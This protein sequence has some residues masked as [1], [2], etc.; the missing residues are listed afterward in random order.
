MTYTIDT[1][2]FLRAVL[3]KKAVKYVNEIISNTAPRGIF[4]QPIGVEAKHKLLDLY[5][6]IVRILNDPTRKK[7]SHGTISLI[8]T[9]LYRHFNEKI[10]GFVEDLTYRFNKKVYEPFFEVRKVRNSK[11]KLDFVLIEKLKIIL[12]FLK[13]ID[14]CRNFYPPL[15]R[16][17]MDQ[18]VANKGL[19]YEMGHF[20]NFVS[21]AIKLKLVYTNRYGKQVGK[22]IDF[23]TTDSNILKNKKLIEDAFEFITIEDYYT[24]NEGDILSSS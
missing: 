4:I 17:F 6:Q 3:N 1:N 15:K 18:S 9:P 13:K 21:N 14:E 24:I 19:R 22:K 12:L 23:I 7:V 5:T 2:V 8:N 16:E 10:P 11:L 20:G